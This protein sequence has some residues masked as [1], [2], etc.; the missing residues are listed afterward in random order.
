MYAT[1]T[2]QLIVGLFAIL[3]IA[4]LAFLSFRLGRIDLFG[5]PG[6]MLF[7]NFDNI[8]GLKNNDRVEIAGVP[9]GHVASISLQNDRAH[10]GLFIEKGVQV[11]SDAIAGIKSS[12]I[13]GDKY[14]AI[15]LGSGDTLPNGG[16]IL[17]TQSAFV[18]EDAIG[19][20]IN[21]LGSGGGSKDKE[22]SK[23]GK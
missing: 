21:S 18:L 17:Q 7:A 9:I 6:Y 12:G 1:R 13:I 14:V 11:D 23:D 20:L 5:S 19:G 8:A 10:L 16:T 3:G 15:Q 2:T 4:A 22:K